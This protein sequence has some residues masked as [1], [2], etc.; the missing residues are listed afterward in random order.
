MKVAIW[1]RQT[2][3]QQSSSSIG[4]FSIFVPAGNNRYKFGVTSKSDFLLL[5]NCKWPDELDKVKMEIQRP[6]SLPDCCALV[7]RYVPAD[8]SNEFVHQEIIKSIRSAVTFSK[9]NYHRPRTTNDYRF[10]ITDE[11]EYDEIL[12]IGRIAIG[13][14]LLPITSF[15][16]GLKMT[17]CNNCWELGHTRPECKIGPLCRKCLEP[18]DY[19]HVC[20]KPV[21][22]AQCKGSHSSLSMECSVVNNYRRTLKNEVNNAVK[23]GFLRQID[24]HRD[25]PVLKQVEGTHAAW[26]GKQGPSQNTLNQQE[27]KQVENLVIQ[28]NAVL[29]INRRMETKMDNQILRLGML[30]KTAAINKQG[31]MVLA[32]I[33]QQTINAM[34]EK[35]NK[36]QLQNLAKQIEDFKDDIME[37]FN[38]LTFDQQQTPTPPSLQTT[39][40]QLIKSTTTSIDN[41]NNKQV[42]QEQSMNITDGQ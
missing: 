2:V 4:E 31:I 33:M 27:N 10:C 28:I 18:W 42:E 22:C 20:Q 39:N 16:P 17:F 23:N 24:Y 15:I 13:H 19:N 34:S 41:E 26:G 38:M 29:D 32:N 12:G 37:K 30:D 40:K 11:S 6:R 8:L 5:W 9:I 21:L 14:S 7:I 3:H 1:L 25:F 35:K 36:Q